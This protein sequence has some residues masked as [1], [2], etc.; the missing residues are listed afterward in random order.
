M[1]ANHHGLTNVGGNGWPQGILNIT[2]RDVIWHGLGNRM[3]KQLF[4]K[5]NSMEIRILKHI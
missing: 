2:I 5:E 3:C 4:H 1:V